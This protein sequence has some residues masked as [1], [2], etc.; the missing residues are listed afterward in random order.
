MTRRNRDHRHVGPSDPYATA[1]AQL[2][3]RD[4]KLCG[5]CEGP[6]GGRALCRACDAQLTAELGPVARRG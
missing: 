4:A 5:S 3:G 6:S 1:V 2:D